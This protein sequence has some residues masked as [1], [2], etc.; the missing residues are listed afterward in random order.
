MFLIILFIILSGC[1]VILASMYYNIVATQATY[2][3]TNTYYWAYYGAISSIE[4]WLLM[5]KL[6]YPTYESSGWF[7]WTQV[8][9]SNSNLLKDFWKLSLWNNSMMR[10]VNSKT[11]KISSY[12]DTKALRNISFY[13]YEDKNADSYTNKG[14]TRTIYWVSDWLSFSWHTV[15]SKWERQTENIKE[16]NMD[17]NRFFQ[18]NATRRTVRSLWYNFEKD[19]MDWIDAKDSPLSWDFEFIGSEINPRPAEEWDLNSDYTIWLHDQEEDNTTPVG[20]D[21]P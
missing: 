2:W 3:N 1:A 18:T 14:I 12:I 11:R 4:R 16:V 10:Y 13:R 6:K 20:Q 7:I 15:P 19:Q 5:T 9:W 21:E 17:F 8:I